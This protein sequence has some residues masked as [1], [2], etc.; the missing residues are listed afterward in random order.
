MCEMASDSLI[1]V[2]EVEASLATVDLDGLVRA[3]VALLCLG[4]SEDV[5]TSKAFPS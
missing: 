3:V 1:A 2:A 5:V 4:A